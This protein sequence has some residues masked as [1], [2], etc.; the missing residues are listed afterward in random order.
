MQKFSQTESKSTSKHHS[1]W[2]E[3]GD[4][5]ERVRKKT[6]GAEENCNPIGRINPDHQPN[7][8]FSSP[9][10]YVAESCLIW[11]QWKGR[12]LVLAG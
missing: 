2:T 4:P 6:E 9:A 8:T 5:N 3:P 12:H 7:Y 10:I 11:H 1:S